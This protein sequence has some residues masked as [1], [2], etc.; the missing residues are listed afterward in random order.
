MPGVVYNPVRRSTSKIPVRFGAKRTPKFTPRLLASKPISSYGP[1]HDQ[2]GY[3]ANNIYV[4]Q[5]KQQGRSGIDARHSHGF[6]RCKSVVCTPRLSVSG[7]VHC[8]LRKWTSF[9]ASGGTTSAFGRDTL[10]GGHQQACR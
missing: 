9:T 5:P 3:Q 1:D 7:C 8:T 6:S 2:T 4:M 10:G